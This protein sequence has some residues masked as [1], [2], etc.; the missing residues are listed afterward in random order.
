M[1]GH[2]D[3]VKL[4]DFGFAQSNITDDKEK[5]F[6]GW[7]APEGKTGDKCDVWSLGVSLYFILTG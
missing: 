1:F 4:V 6:E 3:E 7:E 5:Q 2:G